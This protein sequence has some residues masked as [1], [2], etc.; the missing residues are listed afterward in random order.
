MFKTISEITTYTEMRCILPVPQAVLEHKRRFDCS[1]RAVLDG[2]DSRK[3]LIIGP[4]SLDIP[5]EFLEYSRRLA[6]LARRV[7]DVFTVIP[8]MYSCKPRSSGEGYL[9][10]LHLRDAGG[11]I[12][13]GKNIELIRRLHIENAEQNGL[14][15]ADELLYPSLYPYLSDLLSYVSIGSR[16]SDNQEHRFVASG[17]DIPVGFKNNMSGDLNSLSRSVAAGRRSAEFM[18][19]GRH[20]RTEGNS[21]A[22]AILRGYLGKSN[23]HIQNF[24]DVSLRILAKHYNMLRLGRPS[25]I[26]DANHSNSGKVAANQLHVIAQALSICESNEEYYGQMIGF[27]I[28]S[29][30][31]SGYCARK[32]YGISVTDDCLGFTET[33][34]MVL[35]AADQ[36]RGLALTKN[37]RI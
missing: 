6:S 20:V 21:Y 15:G 34:E 27:M 5:D 35:R 28:E 3:L 26:I 32:T 23:R 7:S 25:V 11:K 14:F 4:C 2:A 12:D 16:S 24:S 13:I 37:K 33:E 8:R 29:Y 31:N 9:G 18:H 19:E 22:H 10:L 36:L 30:L 1:V 17:L